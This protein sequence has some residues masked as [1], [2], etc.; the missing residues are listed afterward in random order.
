MRKNTINKRLPQSLLAG[1]PGHHQLLGK[2]AKK[3]RPIQS[4]SVEMQFSA[5][6]SSLLLLN[7]PILEKIINSTSEAM[8]SMSLLRNLESSGIRN[9]LLVK[10]WTQS[11]KPSRSSE[12]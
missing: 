8:F 11:P 1:I 10:K 5:M 4:S 7:P 9:R 12:V 6:D 3:T 2:P